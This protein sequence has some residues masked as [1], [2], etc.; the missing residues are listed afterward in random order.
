MKDSQS[1]INKTLLIGWDIICVVLT[2]AYLIQFIKGDRSFVYFLAFMLLCWGPM[3]ICFILYRRNSGSD[4]IRTIMMVSFLFLYA[5]ALFTG[6]T[7]YVFVYMFP[8]LPLLMMCN[9][10]RLVVAYELVCVILNIGAVVSWLL[11]RGQNSAADILNYEIQ[12]AVILLTGTLACVGAKVATS[13]SKNLNNTLQALM[14]ASQAIQKQTN[15][16][17]A[18]MEELTNATVITIGSIQEI[19]AGNNKTAESIQSQQSMSADIQ[20]SLEEANEFSTDIVTLS[21]KAADVVQKGINNMT[22]LNEVTN[23]TN[24]RS[25]KVSEQMQVLRENT[26][27]AMKIITM[28]QDIANQTNLLAYNASIEAARAG[29]A[30]RGF[31]V[32][33]GEINSLSTQ[34]KSATAQIADIIENL[35]NEAAT[36]FETIEETVHISTQQNTLIHETDEMFSEIKEDVSTMEAKVKEQKDRIGQ[37]KNANEIISQ[38]VVTISAIVQELAAGSQQTLLASEQN[39]HITESVNQAVGAL[40]TEMNQLSEAI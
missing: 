11:F 25:K 13:M 19:T 28:I 17:S 8:L 9:D 32:V 4:R 36:V 22:S 24:E 7:Q 3:I 5:F 40:Q 21:G 23:L 14:K 6:D 30:G 2:A 27:Q 29:T 15:E 39:R 31:A 1:K 35:R 20:L 18:D 16:I 37:I 33:A 12:L 26:E 38:S 10:Y 34:T